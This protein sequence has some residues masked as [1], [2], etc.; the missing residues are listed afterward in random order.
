[1][2]SFFIIFSSRHRRII[3]VI[4][5]RFITIVIT[6][7][8]EPRDR[9][10]WRRYEKRLRPG[11]PL[12]R[13]RVTRYRF[14]LFF[15]SNDFLELFQ[16]PFFP[17]QSLCNWTFH[18]CAF[19]AFSAVCFPSIRVIRQRDKHDSWKS[20]RCP[21]LISTLEWNQ[22]WNHV[23]RI[24]K[25]DVFFNT[26]LRKPRERRQLALPLTKI[27][28]LDRI[29]SFMQIALRVPNVWLSQQY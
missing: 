22:E 26:I 3:P 27:A 15:Q 29:I 13:D 12:S 20:W 23:K 25:F 10:I 17:L 4:S 8:Y 14:F 6:M 1:M 21:A 19:F 9:E 18:D 28:K 5:Y 16:T 7:F 11:C 24:N 2:R